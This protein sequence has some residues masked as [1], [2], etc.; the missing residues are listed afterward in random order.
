MWILRLTV[1]CI[2]RFDCKEA[3]RDIGKC[4]W[5]RAGVSEDLDEAAVEFCDWSLCET[6][7]SAALMHAFNAEMFFNG[8]GNSEEDWERRCVAGFSEKSV[9]FPRLFQ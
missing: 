7:V 8:D 6:D 9:F 5:D 3:L 1:D 4:E 2:V